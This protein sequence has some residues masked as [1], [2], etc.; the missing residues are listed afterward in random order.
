[1]DARAGGRRYLTVAAVAFVVS[2]LVTACGGSSGEAGK[3]AQ[4]I[5]TDARNA[6]DSATSVHVVGSL[7]VQGQRTPVDVKVSTT[8]ATGTSTFAGKPV[9][10]VRVG[11]NLYVR[12]A[13][14]II[15]SFLGPKAQAAIDDKWL[16]IPTSLPQLAA[17]TSATDKRQLVTQS[18]TPHGTVSKDGTRTVAGHK[19]IALK[20]FGADG[21]GTLLVAATG[22]PYPIQLNDAAGTLSF[23]D[24]NTPVAAQA[25]S[26]SVSLTTLI[27]G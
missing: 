24:W 20:G 5:L 25:P 19:A 4:Q 23:S 16:Q 12:G 17:F 21:N 3:S 13:Q 2:V 7:D 22:T 18:L 11:S 26:Q 1:M 27:G 8:G 9:E 6:A 15:G 14:D 10:L